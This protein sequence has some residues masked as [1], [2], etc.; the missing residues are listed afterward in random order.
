MKAVVG[1]F[2]GEV[3]AFH[4]KQREMNI[5]TVDQMDRERLANPPRCPTRAS[6]MADS[7]VKDIRTG[8]GLAQQHSTR[9]LFKMRKFL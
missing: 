3:G 7:F 6:V 9:S 4:H 1:N 2:Y 5:L 8:S